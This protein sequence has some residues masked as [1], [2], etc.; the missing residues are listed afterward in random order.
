MFSGPVIWARPAFCFVP[1]NDVDLFNLDVTFIHSSPPIL[2]IHFD[3]P[4]T[5]HGSWR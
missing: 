5:S 3:T 1:D 4:G 2:S